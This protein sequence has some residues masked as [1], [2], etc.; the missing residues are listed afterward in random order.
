MTLE[1]HFGSWY[2]L[3]S[4][5]LLSDEFKSLG[6]LI[7]QRRNSFNVNVYPSKD[8]VFKAFRLCDYNKLKVVILSQD[9]YY[10]DGMA[11]GLAFAVNNQLG[12]IPPSLKNIHKEVESDVYDGLQL[13]FDYSLESWAKQGVLL[14]NTALTVEENNPGCHVKYWKNFI[15]F[16]F[17]RLAE[18]KV[19][20][21]YIC[22]GN[23]ARKFI[24][25]FNKHKT[26]FVLQSAHPSPLSAHNGFFGSKPFSF[27]NDIL[28][29]VA[30]GIDED[31]IKYRIKW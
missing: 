10:T 15:N 31:P 4:E 28:S 12:K 30:K 23:H 22:W 8:D 9:P 3:L 25:I 19:G 1:E 2:E 26:N 21:V 6:T 29:E 16:L 11:N 27:T 24:P 14:I 7:N 5:Y 18:D 20:I 17:T 13:D